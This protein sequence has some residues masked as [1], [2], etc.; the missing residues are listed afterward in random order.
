LAA[1]RFWFI[2]HRAAKAP[3]RRRPVSSTLGVMKCIVDSN[4]LGDEALRRY[5]SRSKSNA[6]VL[7]DYVFMEAVKHDP[8]SNA[9]KS[10][11][12]LA[13]YPAQVIVLK[14]T[15]HVSGLHGGSRGLARRLVDVPR[16]REFSIF[17]QALKNAQLGERTMTAELLRLGSE[18]NAHLNAMAEGADE[19]VRVA[20][21]A[22]KAFS[23]EDRSH[24]RQPGNVDLELLKKLFLAAVWQCEALLELHPAIRRLP[25]ADELA[26]TYLFRSSLCHL[27][28]ILKWAFDGGTSPKPTKITNDLVDTHVAAYATYFDD[29]LSKDPTPKEISQKARTVLSQLPSLRRR[30]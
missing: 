2:M 10:F 27:L 21:E 8:L 28:L 26:N 15:Y 5:L 14:T 9:H 4:F 7:T 13:Q 3:C 30:K 11:E 19:F 25:T 6:A 12:I 1:R 29:L 20:A 24:L 16:T 22:A 18:A 17:C 23:K